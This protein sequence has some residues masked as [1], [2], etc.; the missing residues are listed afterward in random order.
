[1]AKRLSAYKGCLLGLAVG[2]AMG[3]PVNQWTLEEIR[4]GYGPEG[5]RGF[6]CLNGYATVTAHTQLAAYA[7]N[8]LLLGLTRG[9]LKGEMAP[10]VRYICVAE[11]EWARQQSYTR[12][13]K[14]F[15]CWVGDDEVIRARRTRD[16]LLVDTLLQNRVGTMEEPRNKRDGASTLPAAAA[17]GMFYEPGRIS[18]AELRRLG[19]ETV[20][21]THGTPAAFLAGA[22]LAHL[23]SRTLYD[24]EKDLKALIAETAEAMQQQFGRDY[25]QGC[26]IVCGALRAVVALAESGEVSEA[27]AMEQMNCDDAARVLA[28]ALYACLMHP[29]DIEAA[30]I[31][32]VN[33]SGKS[34]A[35]AAIAGAILG[36]ML[37]DRSLREFFLPDLE[38]IRCLEPLAADLSQGCPMVRGSA[39]FDFSW[40]EKYVTYRRG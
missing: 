23:L 34:S 35:V 3:R 1:M 22:A 24:G 17:V 5:L 36:S 10:Y 21:L 2:D 38:P 14:P 16:N 25:T 20:A 18:R 31:T 26:G 33:H 13:Q 7:V 11:T 40:D 8:G 12:F 28:G 4:A 19:A 15:F 37:G 32:A 39:M 27:E 30:L 6:D 9:Q 29:D